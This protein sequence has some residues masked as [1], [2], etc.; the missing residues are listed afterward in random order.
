VADPDCRASV[1]HRGGGRRTITTGRP[2][3]RQIR[4]VVGPG[5]FAGEMA[6]LDLLP[7]SA[8]VRATTPM[9]VLVIGPQAFSAFVSHECVAKA[10]ATQ[11]VQRLRRAEA[12]FPS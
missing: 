11:L 5:E 10:M 8:T 9:Q 2:W 1:A 3:N 4:S 6:M 7:R 12:G